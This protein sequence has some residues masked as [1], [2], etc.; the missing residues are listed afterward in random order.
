M[1]GKDYYKIL[2]VEKN[3]TDEDIKKAYRKLAH[4]HHPDIAGGNEQKFKEINEAYQVLGSKEKRIQYDQYGRVFEGGHGGP[5][6]FGGF[7]FDPSQFGDFADLGDIFGDIFGGFGFGGS[8]RKTHRRGSDLEMRVEITLEE[9]LHGVKKDLSIDTYLPCEKCAGAGHFSKEG[10][11]N[12]GNCDGRGQI[13]EVKS[14]F[15]GAFS[16]VRECPKCSGSGKIPKKIC[17]ICSGS[18]RARGRRDVVINLAPGIGDGQMLKVSGAGEAGEKG[19]GTGD[20]YVGVRVKPHSVFSRVGDDLVMKL[21]V[22]L[23]DILLN[24]PLHITTLSGKK[25]ETAVPEDFNLKN[26]LKISGEGMPHFGHYGRGDLYIDLDVKTP[27]R[28]SASAKKILEAL[29]KEL[30]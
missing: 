28:L 15:F 17:G 7:N 9:A 5:G 13:K 3:A 21:P 12:C 4:V 6:G 24:A 8:A 30:N 22:S 25:I 16:R 19:A 23:T 2:G 14:G 11:E 18:G 1:A 27:K 26:K 20:L 10:F 29:R